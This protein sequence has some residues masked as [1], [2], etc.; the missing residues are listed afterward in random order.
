MYLFRI[1]SIDEIRERG[2]S[3]IDGAAVRGVVLTPLVR[4]ELLA[5]VQRGDHRT[6]LLGL[7]FPLELRQAD[8][9]LEI[10][11]HVRGLVLRLGPGGVQRGGRR[12]GGQSG[13]KLLLVLQSD[14]PDN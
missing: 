10:P 9:V 12:E 5:G 7:E 2:M 8:N 14:S 6:E 11:E 3:E 1:N 13:Q 4:S